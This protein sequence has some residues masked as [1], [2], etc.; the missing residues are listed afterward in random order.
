MESVFPSGALCNP[1][2]PSIFLQRPTQKIQVHLLIHTGDIYQVQKLGH[3]HLGAH[4]SSYVHHNV[5]HMIRTSLKEE[6]RL[7]TSLDTLE[8]VK[9]REQNM[10]SSSTLN[11]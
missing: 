10:P 4:C 11:C 9:D 6:C 8:I 5:H 3:E 2:T 1:L 7:A